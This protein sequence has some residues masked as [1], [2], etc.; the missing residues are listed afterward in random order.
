MN[1]Q[2]RSEGPL[3]GNLFITKAHHKS[4]Y[5]FKLKGRRKKGKDSEDKERNKEN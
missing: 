5:G 3:L 4:H 1:E 2:E